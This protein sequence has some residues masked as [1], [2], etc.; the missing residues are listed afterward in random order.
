M[1]TALFLASLKEAMPFVSPVFGS[2]MVLQRDRVNPIW[3][4]ASPGSS[5]TVKV[6]GKSF[7]ATTAADGKWMAKVTPPPTGGPYTIEIKG[8]HQVT[9]DDVMVGDVWICS[10]Q[11]NMEMGI[12]QVKDAQAEIAAAKHPG[13]RL[14][15]VSR[16]TSLSDVAVPAG[17]WS[18]C[19]PESIVK[20]GWG[21]FSG[22]GYFFG[23]ELHNR[24]KVPIGLVET[25]WGGTVAEAWTSDAGLKPLKDFDQALAVNA[26]RTKPGAPSLGQLFAAWCRAND[27]LSAGHPAASD[28]AFDDSGWKSFD[29]MAMIDQ[30]GMSGFDGVVW[31]RH[32]VE[33]PDPVP[34][35]D[36]VLTLGGVDDAASVWVNG[37]FVGE[38]FSSMVW[39]QYKLRPGLLRPGKNVIA[40]RLLDTGGPGG[41]TSGPDSMKL[42]LP[43]KEVSLAG[44]WRVKAGADLSKVSAPPMFVEGNPNWPTALFHGMIAPLTPMAV[45]GAI[46]YQG[47]SNAGR[48]A[49]Y[50]RLLPAMIADWR[51]VFNYKDLPF[52][53]VQLANFAE[54]HPQPVDD[55]WAEL[56]EAQ[57]K[58]VATTPNTGLA[59]A[60][61]IGEGPDIHPKNKQDVG[62]RLALSAL[63]VAYKQPVEN[64]GPTFR[65]A[66]VEGSS[67][68]VIFDHAQG[69]KASGGVVKGFQ[70]AGADGKFVWAD[71][72]IDGTT[73]VL[74]ADGVSKPVSVRYAWDSNPEVSLYNSSNLPAVPFRTR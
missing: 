29:R 3:G 56:R 16:A 45:R 67:L 26:E 23:R 60:I 46:W 4:W 14:F 6:A 31:M 28:E 7:R 39:Q 13:I 15:M 55:A 40:V 34:T 18:V 32:Q 52:F 10:G 22:V 71:A 21:G 11:S 33:V 35:G 27:S 37:E 53:V 51:R 24:L 30:M 41:I 64:E 62:L 73:V 49:Q 38:A 66:R 9:F 48:A 50:Q 2:H 42:Y 17:S 70:L 1:L 19:S 68:R 58:T 44:P 57:T 47:E 63:K 72:K 20:D 36:V 61:D 74:R 54:R 5:V 59:V 12:S 8:D 25:S 43:G 65:A 69:L